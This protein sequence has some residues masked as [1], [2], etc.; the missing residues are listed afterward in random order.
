MLLSEVPRVSADSSLHRVV[1]CEARLSLTWLE[2]QAF[3]NDLRAAKRPE[4][5]SLILAQMEMQAISKQKDVWCV[6]S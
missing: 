2:R 1:A 3:P 4:K 5:L 6:G